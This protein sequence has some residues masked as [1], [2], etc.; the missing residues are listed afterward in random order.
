MLAQDGWSAAALFVPIMR[1]RVTAAQAVNVTTVGAAEFAIVGDDPVA[2]CA[3]P[4]PAPSPPPRPGEADVSIG[5]GRP[6]ASV[7]RPAS[8]IV[9]VPARAAYD[10]NALI[11]GRTQ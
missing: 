4:A 10:T 7:H 5:A 9:D 6:S 3:R 1:A 2:G 8:S 11:L